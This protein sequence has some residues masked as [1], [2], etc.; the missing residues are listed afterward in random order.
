MKTRKHL[1][2]LKVSVSSGISAIGRGKKTIL[3]LDYFA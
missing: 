1:E 3:V 2:E